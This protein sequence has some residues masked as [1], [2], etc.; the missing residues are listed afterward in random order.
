MSEGFF[1]RWSQRKEEVRKG[2]EPAPEPKQVASPELPSP[3]A[4]IPAPPA[5]EE[6]APTLED[7]HALTQDSDFTRFVKPDVAP[8]VKNAALKKLFSDPHFNTMDGLDTY[9]DDY[10]KPDPLPESMLKQ[11]ASAKFLGLV[12]EPQA[13]TPPGTTPE[14]EGAQAVAQSALCNDLPR[15]ADASSHTAA[16]PDHADP[17]LR[18]QQDD[19]PG[20]AGPGER[21]A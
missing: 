5:P 8:E 10:N 12:D 11:L 18:L 7:A 20:P 15:P 13:K 21:P 9:I 6:P 17:D 4:E 14:G 1:S 19:A 2:K 16:G 3:S